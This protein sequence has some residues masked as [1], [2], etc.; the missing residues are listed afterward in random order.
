MFIPLP[1][2]IAALVIF[3][4]L[5]WSNSKNSQKKTTLDLD[6]TRMGTMTVSQAYHIASCYGDSVVKLTE[7]RTKAAIEEDRRSLRS[8]A[9]Q[10]GYLSHTTSQIRAALMLTV[11][12]GV[13]NT[14]GDRGQF[15]TQREYA[16]HCINVGIFPFN[17]ELRPDIPLDFVNQCYLIYDEVFSSCTPDDIE[18]YTSLARDAYRRYWEKIYGKIS[19]PY[20]SASDDFQKMVLERLGNAQ[21]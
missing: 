16:V 10:S 4:L 15:R 1:I 2:L 3:C 12:Q 5:L 19:L 21:F 13:L 18:K 9:Y 6:S 7:A 14:K 20:T 11:A 8:S 17:D